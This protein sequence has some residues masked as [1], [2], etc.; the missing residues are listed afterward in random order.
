MRCPDRLPQILLDQRGKLA[1]QPCHL[2]LGEPGCLRERHHDLGL[3]QRFFGGV[4]ST[5]V[6]FG[7]MCRKTL[8]GLVVIARGLHSFKRNLA[9]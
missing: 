2:L 5:T 7:E 3:V 8:N 9:Q 1:K 4:S 6:P